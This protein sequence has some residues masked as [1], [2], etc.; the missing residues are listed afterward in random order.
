MLASFN[1]V[2][3]YTSMYV[4]TGADIKREK[5]KEAG[6]ATAANAANRVADGSPSSA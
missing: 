2:T 1:L 4:P 5:E 6:P 3:P